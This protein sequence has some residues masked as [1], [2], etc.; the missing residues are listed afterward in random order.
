[1]KMAHLS[2]HIVCMNSELRGEQKSALYQDPRAQIGKHQQTSTYLSI[3]NR[4]CASN[5]PN[6]F[7]VSIRIIK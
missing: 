5:L 7:A 1:M 2:N 4:S 3:V 6:L